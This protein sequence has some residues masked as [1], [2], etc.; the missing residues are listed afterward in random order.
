MNEAGVSGSVRMKQAVAIIPARGGSKGIPRKNVRDV[1]G[2]PMIA[3]TIEAARR[4]ETVSRVV[5]STDDDEIAAVSERWG[6]LVVRRPSEIAG[7][8]AT[9]ESALLHTLDE[10]EKAG[11]V[12]DVVAF[13][14]CTSP[15]TAAEDIDG[16]VRLVLSGE[17]DSALAVCAF[18]YF[19]WR[20]GAAQTEAGASGVNHDKAGR[21][22][23][24][25]REAEWLETG[26]VYAMTTDGLRAHGHRF[27]GVTRTHETP[28]SRRLEID[29]PADLELADTILRARA[30]E[31]LAGSLPETVGALVLD[32]DGV[33][34]DNAVYL[35]QDGIESVRC[36]RGD[37]L[38]IG[39]VRA[40]GVPVL[41]LSKE[42]NPVVRA[43]AGKLKVECLQAI[44]DKVAA[45][46]RW[47]TEQGIDAASVVFVGND[48]ND[49]GVMGVV[50]CP[51]AV[52]DAHETALRA[53]K[54]VTG[55][56]GG[57]GAVREVCDAIAGRVGRPAGG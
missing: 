38:G 27:F 50:G 54:A 9:S 2:R 19:L 51:V 34:T 30:G 11:R 10:M 57:H 21:Q 41:I 13:L 45:L 18:H 23:R 40:A 35:N 49:V 12:E 4:A 29:E 26:A 22:M 42:R 16:T 53:A 3:W 25:Q 6:A 48:V 55:R 32:F 8:T 56:P 46:E 36:D 43:R 28:V 31:R 7:D 33:L 24:Q 44:D 20:D 47:C 1:A 17:A 15:L 39:L 5:V 14:Q 37:G 52:A